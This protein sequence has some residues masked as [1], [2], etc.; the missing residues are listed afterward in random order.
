MVIDWG[1]KEIDNFPNGRISPLT[2]NPRISRF[3][4]SGVIYEITHQYL[5]NPNVSD[6]I[7]D[8]P[9][10]VTVG[11]DALNRIQFNDSQG[12]ITSLS[13][14][15]S[16]SLVVP[17]AGL[18]TLRLELP[19]AAT[20][21]SRFVFSNSEFV[22]SDNA[23][24]IPVGSAEIVVSSGGSAVEKGRSYVLRVITPVN[25]QGEISASEDIELTDKDIEDLSSGKLFQKLGD[26]RYRVYLIREDG[27]ELL[28]KDF[29]L[30]N[31]RP[32]DVDDSEST[33][34]DMP[35]D[36]RVLEQDS[37]SVP[38]LNPEIAAMMDE[39]QELKEPDVVERDGISIEAKGAE[40]SIADATLAV[41]SAVQAMRSW[42]KAARRFRA[43]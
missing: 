26:N 3:D 19:Q 30:R 11:V 33:Q 4:A 36:E 12:A 23:V 38:S 6:P 1:D 7:A 16:Q 14:V 22:Q 15:A 5:G 28:L 10:K 17:A 29:Y 40:K 34:N 21:L 32:V 2:T 18:F 41:G 9:V 35:S 8:I 27:N 24:A 37:A 42:R 20:A 39:E 25:E 31:H 13:E 43:G